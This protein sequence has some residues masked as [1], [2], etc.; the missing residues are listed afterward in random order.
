MG[1]FNLPLKSYFRCYDGY[2]SWFL[3]SQHDGW[4]ILVVAKGIVAW[5]VGP[6]TR[7][8]KGDNPTSNMV[9]WDCGIWGKELNPTSNVIWYMSL[10]VCVCVHCILRIQELIIKSM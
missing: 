5:Q 7:G 8:T 1:L 10:C 3:Q 2:F 9:R 4:L 6:F